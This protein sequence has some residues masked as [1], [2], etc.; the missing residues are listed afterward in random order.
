M[1]A[2]L[3]LYVL[4]GVVCAVNLYDHD[5][6]EEAKKYH[7]LFV[8]YSSLVFSFILVVVL[9]PIAVYDRATGG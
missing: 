2:L 7:P 9:W 6:V 3:Y 1:E 4:I 8:V 5:S